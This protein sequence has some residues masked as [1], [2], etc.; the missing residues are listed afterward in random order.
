MTSD[1]SGGVTP[2]V[3]GGELVAA[4]PQLAEL[5]ELEVVQFRQEPSCHL[6]LSDCIALARAID[7][8]GA[9]GAQGVVVT[10]GTDTIEETAFALDLLLSNGPPLVVTGAMRNPRQ[11]GADGPSNLL[12]AALA[13]LSPACRNLGVLVCLND[14]I[15]AARHVIKGD[16]QNPDAF[17]SGVHGILGRVLEGRVSLINPIAW[18]APGLLKGVKGEVAYV[19]LLKAFIGDDGRLVRAAE[20]EGCMGL[21]VE[22]MGAGHLPPAMADSLAALARNMPVLLCSRTRAGE[23]FTSTYGFVGSEMD[24]LRRG[25]L[26]GGWLDGLKARV[27]LSLS[28]T[29]G[30][31]HETIWTALRLYGGTG[32][33]V[34]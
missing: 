20:S 3:S 9:A 6:G 17:T 2:A 30:H 13:A 16:T 11:P 34:T 1:G 24:L 18:N 12:A 27:L 7:D 28:L 32:P 31:S 10:Q 15:H 23:V 14:R 5:A 21:V 29:A 33:E 25:L 26:H 19:P 4:V 8:A 22:A